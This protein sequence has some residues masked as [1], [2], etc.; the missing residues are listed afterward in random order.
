[1][2]EKKERF[3]LIIPCAI[4]APRPYISCEVTRKRKAVK[5]SK[6]SVVHIPGTCIRG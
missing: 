4:G 3:L 1:M 6:Y 5:D 2:R